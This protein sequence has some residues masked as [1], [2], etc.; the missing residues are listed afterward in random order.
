[1]EQKHKQR[2]RGLVVSDKMEKTVVVKVTRLRKHPLY[3][4]FMKRSKRYKAHD[5]RNEY[6][7]GD[8]VIIEAS[9]PISRDKRWKV[10]SKI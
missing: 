8:R 1:M 10:V 2:L 7:I 5:E 3:K 9:K 4:K 6:H